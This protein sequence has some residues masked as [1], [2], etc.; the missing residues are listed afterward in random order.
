MRKQSFLVESFMMRVHDLQK[1]LD[2]GLLFGDGEVINAEVVF[3]RLSYLYYC[4]I[5]FNA[6]LFSIIEASQHLQTTEF[7]KAPTKAETA[8]HW[9]GAL[10]GFLKRCLLETKPK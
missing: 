5:F 7:V 2:V 8:N 4:T 10:T 3:I 1:S 6:W 9:R